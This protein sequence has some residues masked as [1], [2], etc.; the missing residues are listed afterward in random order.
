VPK[1]YR[2]VFEFLA[3]PFGGFV[4][5]LQVAPRTEALARVHVD[6]H[7][8]ALGVFALGTGELELLVPASVSFGNLGGIH[9]VTIPPRLHCVNQSP[10]QSAACDE[11]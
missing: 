10:C 11:T 1:P 3:E 9:V 7:G 6:G 5:A 2:H 4:D 8:E